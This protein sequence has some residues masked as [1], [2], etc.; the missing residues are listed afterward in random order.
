M[1][2]LHSH[3]LP[4]IDD[5][6]P[7]W[8]QTIEMARIAAADGVTCLALTPHIMAGSFMPDRETVLDLIGEMAVRL[9]KAGIDLTLVPGSEVYLS[10]EVPQLAQAGQ[11]TTINDGGRYV[12]LELPMLEYPLFAQ[13]VLFRLQ[14]QGLAPILAHPERN[15]VLA[16]DPT[17]PRELVRRG[18]LVQMNAGSLLGQYGRQVQRAALANGATGA[19]T[20]PGFRPPLG[21]ARTGDACRGGADQGPGRSVDSAQ[22]LVEQPMGYSGE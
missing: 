1:Y 8:E 6:S 19:G 5:G 16:A 7:G 12:L 21:P 14:L 22:D 10:P 20:H 17:R 11:I 18:I 13:D 2:D 15:R 9:K 4:G 3:L